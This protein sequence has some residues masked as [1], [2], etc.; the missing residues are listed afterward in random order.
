MSSKLLS[1]FSLPLLFPFFY[2]NEAQTQN[3]RR[4]KKRVISIIQSTN[5]PQQ[6]NQKAKHQKK[7]IK[8]KKKKIKQNRKTKKK[9]MNTNSTIKSVR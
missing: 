4:V 9:Q 1:S 5:L 8:N 2:I 7:K 6:E 3:L